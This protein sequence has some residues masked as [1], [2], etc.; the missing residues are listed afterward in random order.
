MKALIIMFLIMSAMF[1]L[2]VYAAVTVPLSEY[3]RLV[4]D[5]AQAEYLRKHKE[6][7][8]EQLQN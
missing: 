6:M 5:E 1:A 2:I 4:D 8:D 7:Q 3:D